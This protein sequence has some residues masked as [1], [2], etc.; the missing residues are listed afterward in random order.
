M[1]LLMDNLPL[2]SV[3]V[4]CYN[5]E[6]FISTCINSILSQSYPNIQLIVLDDGSTDSSASILKEYSEKFGFYFEAQANLGLAKTL[7]KAINNYAKGKYISC[8]ASDDY[9][10]VDKIKTQV[11]FLEQHK[12]K[13]MVFGKA[14]MID[15]N[16]QPIGVLGEGIDQQD[17][18]FERLLQENKVIASTA[19]IR[20]DILDAVGGFNETIYIEDWEL[21]LR[22]AIKH[23]IGFIDEI[24]GF[25]RRHDHNMSSNLIK[26]LGA[27]TEII[28]QWCHHP[29]YPQYYKRHILEKARLLEMASF[30]KES[31][32]VLWE[33]KRYLFAAHYM[34]TC[35]K[36]MLLW[37]S[38]KK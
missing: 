30:K 14:Q 26:M 13:A 35:L 34:K 10:D 32:Q 3:I 19:M 12:N 27:G 15:A 18:K 31:I 8:I 38:A 24:Q 1:L 28:N 25:Y 36:L 20:K 6:R 37:R 4:P 21:W 11:E 2:V 23:Q 17:L 33:H 5:H 9:W 29:L 7:N 22:I 16:K